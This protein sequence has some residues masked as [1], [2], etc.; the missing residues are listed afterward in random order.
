M[1]NSAYI[2]Q[3]TAPRV[4][5]IVLILGLYVTDILR[6]CI[7]NFNADKMRFVKFTVF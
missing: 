6:V 1:V 2:V 5:S 4:C 7:K 3:S